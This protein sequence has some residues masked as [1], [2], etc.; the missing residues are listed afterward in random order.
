VQECGRKLG[1][2]L[3]ARER[4]QSEAKRL[5]LFQRYIPEVAAAMSSILGIPKEGIAKSFQ[6]ALPRFVNV[7]SE[8]PGEEPPPTGG[9]SMPPPASDSTPP[10]P[11]PPAA[12]AKPAKAAKA[13]PPKPAPAKPAKGGKI[14]PKQL[15]LV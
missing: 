9:G 7:A 1:I 12:A 6:A 8:A 4:E 14:N 15:S 5:G 13:A 2:H 11:V 10:P 3:R